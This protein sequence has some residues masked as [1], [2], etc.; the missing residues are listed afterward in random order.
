MILS[1]AEDNI[2]DFGFQ[3]TDIYNNP[4]EYLNGT[5]PA[6]AT[7][8]VCHCNVYGVDCERNDSP[9]SFIWYD[10]LHPTEQADRIL[11]KEFVNVASGHSKYATYWS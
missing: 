10:E 8:F 7:G 3:F 9:D 4:K 5:A 11:A 1:D 2:A 6:N